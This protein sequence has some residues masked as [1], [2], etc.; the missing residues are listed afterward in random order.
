M[1]DVAC[2]EV[3]HAASIVCSLEVRL[4]ALTLAVARRILQVGRQ[5][6]VLDCVVMC[7]DIPHSAGRR[8]RGH[9]FSSRTSC[10]QSLLSRAYRLAAAAARPPR[11]CVFCVRFL[12]CHSSHLFLSAA[13]AHARI[14]RT[15]VCGLRGCAEASVARPAPCSE[16]FWR[17]HT[18]SPSLLRARTLGPQT[19]AFPNT[20]WRVVARALVRSPLLPRL[21]C[22]V[23][24]GVASANRIAALPRNT[25]RRAPARTCSRMR[26]GNGGGAVAAAAMR[27]DIGCRV[28]ESPEPVASLASVSVS[29]CITCTLQS[30]PALFWAY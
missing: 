30:I 13:C 26:S 9:N 16:L 17:H 1:Q 18:T 3:K 23:T 4:S 28:D 2:A 29:L 6:T 12:T 19:R 11:R 15:C 10:S 21:R 14:Q 24:S 20:L 22:G 27:C 5:L 25:P 7:C 8:N